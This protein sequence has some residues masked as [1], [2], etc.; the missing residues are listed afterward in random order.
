[1]QRQKHRSTKNTVGKKIR[2]LK[3]PMGQKK[4]YPPQKNKV[5]FLVLIS[6]SQLT[7]LLLVEQV[8]IVQ[9]YRVCKHLALQI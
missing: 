6:K 7:A 8:L 3:V 5:F 9:S 1:M 4:K 2:K